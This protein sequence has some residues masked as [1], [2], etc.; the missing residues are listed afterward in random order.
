[1]SSPAPQPL[2]RLRPLGLG[3]ILDEVFR[4]YRR[5][6]WLLAG[7][8]LVLSV[9]GLLLQF[10]SGS[11]D[12]FGF[13]V[14]I[15]GSLGNPSSIAARQPPSPPNVVVL[16]LGYVVF[17]LT[18][19]FTLGAIT[20]AAI[21]LVQGQPVGVGRALAG[22]ARRYWAVLG[23]SLL[24]G[25]VSPLLLCPPLGIWLFVRWVVA[26]P[27]LLAERVGP[28]RALDRS[29]TL[30]RGNWWRLFGILLVMYLLQSV[31]SG[32]LGV[33]AFPIA[34]AVPFVPA[35]VRGAIILTLETLAGALVQPLVYLTVVLLYFDLR[36]RR[37]DFD[38]DQLARQAVG[39][40]T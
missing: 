2:L 38:L 21:D 29:W 6:F 25:L 19:P 30:T 8:G 35:V 34:V 3:E 40:A 39:P 26:V 33:F 7:I 15:L 4:V 24:L 36:I 20:Q 5:H 22:V 32:A 14:S 1:V 13:F 10:A 37:E 11:A 9:P 31:V 17:L 12:Q 28:I 27:A 18:I 16:G 23:L